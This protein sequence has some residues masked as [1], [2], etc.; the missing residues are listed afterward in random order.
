MF[1]AKQEKVLAIDGDYIHLMPPENR[2]STSKTVQYA[3]S[4]S[5]IMSVPYNNAL[6]LTK[7]PLILL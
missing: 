1:S 4:R 2:V 5:L 7:H 3:Y 6:M